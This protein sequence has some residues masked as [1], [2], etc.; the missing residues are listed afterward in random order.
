MTIALST[1]ITGFSDFIGDKVV[2]STADSGDAT[3]LVD[4]A[5]AIYGDGW[6][7]EYY[8]YITSGSASGDDRRI[9]AFTQ[10]T[11]TVEPYV[12]FSAAIAIGNTFQIKK[13]DTTQAIQA[14]NDAIISLFTKERLYRKV[15]FESLG[16]SL[17]ASNANAAQADVIVADATLFFAGQEVTIADDNDSEDCTIDSINT[18]TNTLTMDAVLTNSYTTAANAKV[19]AKSGQYFNLGSTIG[20]ARV[21]GLFIKL[22]ET[23]KRKRYTAWEVITNSSGVRQL[24]FSSSISVDDQTWVIEAIDKLEEVADPT[25]T[26]TLEDRR[27]DLLYAESAYHFY[28]RQANDVSSGDYEPL[29]ALAG[30]YRQ[31]ALGDFRSLQMAKPVEVA[32][33]NIYD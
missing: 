17:L 9:Q 30:R 27:V 19:T 10:L 24:Y 4:A 20:D 6:F 8:I 3:K 1:L 14:I 22:D 25:D 2:E 26:I 16:L 5:L 32:D 18:T 12:N 31:Q 7:A 23:S 33:I 13:T 29:M 11:G 28:L 21:T 15:V